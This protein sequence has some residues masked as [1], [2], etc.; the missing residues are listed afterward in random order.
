MRLSGQFEREAA[1][2]QQ[3]QGGRGAILDGDEDGVDE[4]VELESRR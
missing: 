1:L 2:R 4:G 3:Q